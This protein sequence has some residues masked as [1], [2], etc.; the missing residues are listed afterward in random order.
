MGCFRVLS[1]WSQSDYGHRYYQPFCSNRI[2][3]VGWYCP[4]FSLA[5]WYSRGLVEAH[6]ICSFVG[7]LGPYTFALSFLLFLQSSS[8][9]ECVGE[10]DGEID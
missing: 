2:F 10:I 7:L 5:S 8:W 1:T 4:L 6:E 9:E 3:L